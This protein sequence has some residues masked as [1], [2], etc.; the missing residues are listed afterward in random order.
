MSELSGVNQRVAIAP[1]NVK[2]NNDSKNESWQSGILSQNSLALP[3]VLGGQTKSNIT[4]FN[5]DEVKTPTDISFRE[6]CF[7]N[8]KNEPE[9]IQE[10]ISKYNDNPKQ[11]NIIA[12]IIKRACDGWG[13]DEKAFDVAFDNVSIYNYK[14]VNATLQKIYGRKLEDCI[15]EEFNSEEATDYAFKLAQKV[16]NKYQQQIEGLE[17]KNNELQ[18]QNTSLTVENSNLKTH[19]DSLLASLYDA[20]QRNVDLQEEN[21]ALKEEKKKKDSQQQDYILYSI[22]D[23]NFKNNAYMPDYMPDSGYNTHDNL[24]R[25][26][27]RNH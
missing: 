1:E 24:Q 6:K 14:S 13:T 20:K 25:R 10:F 2:K 7:I 5:P 4:T 18:Q 9:K 3:F 22:D 23:F 21:E 15:K 16:V 12:E 8:A 19:R 11:A 17:S 27:Y 26:F